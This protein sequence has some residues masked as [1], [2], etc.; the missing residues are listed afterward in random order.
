MQ[1]GKE[2]RG[3]DT[4]SAPRLIFH[5]FDGSLLARRGRY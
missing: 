3:I 4:P 1:T 2:T 5:E